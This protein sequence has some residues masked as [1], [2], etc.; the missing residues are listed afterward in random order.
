MLPLALAPRQGKLH[1][2]AGVMDITK[3]EAL[4]KV[5]KTLKDVKTNYSKAEAALRQF[6]G[7]EGEEG[8]AGEEGD[9]K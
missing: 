9:D 6:Y 7:S 1:D 4:D 3:E 2:E 8:E 5:E